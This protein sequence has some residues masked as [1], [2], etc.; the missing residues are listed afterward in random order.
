MMRVKQVSNV[1]VSDLSLIFQ[2]VSGEPWAFLLDSASPSHPDSQWDIAVFDPFKTITFRDGEASITDRRSGTTIR[3]RQDPFDL[4]HQLLAR[5]F[6]HQSD[7]TLP[8]MGGALGYWSYDLGRE[9]ESL[10]AMATPDISLPQMCIGL[11][12]Q[13]VLL[14]KQSG[15]IYLV[16]GDDM[17][18]NA[19]E[20]QLL[21]TGTE[22][23][24]AKRQA[25][26]LR[27]DWRSNMTQAEYA[28]KFT[29][30]HEYL[31]SGDCYQINLAQRFQA[32]Y[33]GDEWDAYR[34]LREANAAPFSAFMRLE[35]GCILSISP[36]RFVQ[37]HQRDIETKPIKGTRPR[38]AAPQADAAAA[39]EL[40][41]AEKDRAENLM[42][43]DLL[44]ND[45]G[46]VAK[47]GS[48]KV[49]KLFEV[50]SFPAV[51][52]LVS[53]IT[54]ELAEG[55][56][57]SDLLRG[58]FP[59]GSITGAPKIRAMQIIEELEPHRR[60]IYCGAI[61]YLSANGNMDSNIAIRT[62]VCENQQI[63][64]WGG[65]GIV[66]DSV[67]DSEYRET[68]DKLQRILPVLSDTQESCS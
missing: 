50:E 57:A 53:T 44:R 41:H 43:V 49:P 12:D 38:F 68:L 7:Q 60:H 47:P 45:L 31:L 9:I 19:L 46:K 2:A 22:L 54:A 40:R 20:Q 14:H 3:T 34:K 25:F 16:A 13:A 35:Q 1:P 27:S 36:E 59:G 4:V 17:Q 6:P 62:L 30:I 52:H 8:F 51:H 24:Q 18:L 65:G 55:R 15:Q 37:V 56:H 48:V 26:S 21:A 61:G 66:A 42:I 29:R 28:E 67:C 64:A 33:Q 11:Y 58:A 32:E 5:H 23:E 39:S 63:Y 10:P